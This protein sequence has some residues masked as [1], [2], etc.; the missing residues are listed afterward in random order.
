MSCATPSLPVPEFTPDFLKTIHE[1]QE[2]FGRDATAAGKMATEI[3]ERFR[4]MFVVFHDEQIC[5]AAVGLDDALETG[6]RIS[7]RPRSNLF[8]QYVPLKPLRWIL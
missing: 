6:E 4:G 8:V 3:Q 2:R 7:G 5:T 1:R